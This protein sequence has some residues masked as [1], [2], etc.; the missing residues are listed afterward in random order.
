LAITGPA[1]ATGLRLEP[2]LTD[3]ILDDLRAASTSPVAGVLPLLSQAMILTWENRDGN[4]LTRHG[5]SNTGGVSHAVQ[6]SADTTYDALP[7][8][9]QALAREILRSMTV[10]DRDNRLTRRPVT[11]AALAGLRGPGQ[12]PAETVVEKFAERR[13]IVLGDGTAEIAHD[14][15]LTAWPR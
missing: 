2:G 5:Y 12:S 7:D 13:L 6:I 3:T 14:A 9:A 10:A 15:L 11:Q 8:A 4:Q 1:A